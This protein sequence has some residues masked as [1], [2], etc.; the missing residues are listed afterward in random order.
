MKQNKAILYESQMNSKSGKRK[1]AH[2]YGWTDGLCL[3][4]PDYHS[5]PVLSPS[6]SFPC[7]YSKGCLSNSLLF[8]HETDV[9]SNAGV[10]HG[11]GLSVQGLPVNNNGKCSLIPRPHIYSWTYKKRLEVSVFYGLK[12]GFQFS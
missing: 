3:H 2:E 1:I 4:Y 10:V 7:S 6:F 11:V 8:S 12:W 5:I 9:C